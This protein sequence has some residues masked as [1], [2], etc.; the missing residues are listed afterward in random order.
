MSKN[1]FGVCTPILN[2]ATDKQSIPQKKDA[3]LSC[4]GIEKVRAI[5][6][7]LNSVVTKLN[8]K[9]LRGHMTVLQDLTVIYDKE[10][11]KSVMGI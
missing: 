10:P 2:I 11:F 8:I 6:L 4:L 7:I 5:V 1:N 9:Y 3:K